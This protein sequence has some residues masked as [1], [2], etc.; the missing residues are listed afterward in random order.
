MFM[1]AIGIAEVVLHVPNDR[2]LP[3]SEI[4]GA[5]HTDIDRN[6]AEVRVGGTDQRFQR[7]SFETSPIFTDLHSIDALETDDVAIEEIPVE[8][9]WEMSTGEQRCPGART[10]WTVPEFLHRIVL[11]RIIDVAAEGWAEISVIPC[12]VRDEI[13]APIIKHAPVR[14]GEIVRHV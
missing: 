10:R 9:V 12:R 7:L 14:I 13:V 1:I 8:I 3:I 4:H 6:W 11:R 5:I 2:V